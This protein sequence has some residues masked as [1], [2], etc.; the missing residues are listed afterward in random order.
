M[1]HTHCPTCGRKFNTHKQAPTAVDTADMTDAQLFA[2]YKKTAVAEDLAFF[3]RCPDLSPELRAQGEAIAT[4]NKTEIA[5][6]RTLWAD[7]AASVGAVRRDPGHW[8]AADLG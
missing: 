4:P 1:E 3:L 8:F 5:R 2:Q 7:G 6:L